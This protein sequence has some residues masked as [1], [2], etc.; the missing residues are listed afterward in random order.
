MSLLWP[1]QCM[2]L[3]HRGLGVTEKNNAVSGLG[4]WGAGVASWEAGTA[5]LSLCCWVT[6]PGQSIKT[7]SHFCSARWLGSGV[8]SA[9]QYA[10]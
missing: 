3:S 10:L 2:A 4:P 6:P 8:F 5:W 9:T 7:A 1:S